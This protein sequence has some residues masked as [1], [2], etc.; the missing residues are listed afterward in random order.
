[1]AHKGS[2]NEEESRDV[3]RFQS[4]LEDVD[5]AAYK[6]VDESMDVHTT[7]NKGFKKA[8]VIWAGSERA[9]N[10]KNDNIN[11]DLTGMIVLPVISIERTSVEKDEK[12]RVIPWSK[13]DPINDLKGGFLT[14]NRVI[15]QDKTRN[16]ANADAFRRRG[17]KNFPL[18]KGKGGKNSKIVYETVTIPIPIYVNVGY[19]IVLRTE[20]QEQM[21]DLL[22]PFIRISNAHTRV[23]IEHNSN[24]YE[25]FVG[26]KYTMEN[27]ISSYKE[28]ERKYETTVKLNVFGYLIGDGK[29]QKQPRVVRRENAVQIRFARERIVV[30]DE[31]GE[32]R[33]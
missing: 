12:A 5:F 4:T 18:Y 29:N 26:E 24:R 2:I 8:P 14:I 15:Q 3:A 9:H 28:E 11:R 27:N 32:F 31:D 6:F 30:E 16:F 21:N 1:M 19:D 20:Y 7:T 23:L 33:F 13:L 10:I 25:A 17:Q 22:V